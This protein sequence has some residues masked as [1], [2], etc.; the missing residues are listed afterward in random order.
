M[1]NGKLEWGVFSLLLHLVMKSILLSGLFASYH[2]EA[3][4]IIEVEC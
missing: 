4:V 1:L 3:L 2:E